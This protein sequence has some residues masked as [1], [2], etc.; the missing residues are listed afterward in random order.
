MEIHVKI[1]SFDFNF[2]YFQ[3]FNFNNYIKT[4]VEAE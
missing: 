2:S 4:Q 3:V 1:P